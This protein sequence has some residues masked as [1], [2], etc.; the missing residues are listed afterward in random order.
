MQDMPLAVGRVPALFALLAHILLAEEQV[1]AQCVLLALPPAML[2]P[3]GVSAAQL[4][5]TDLVGDCARIV[6]QGNTVLLSELIALP[7][8]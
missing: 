6:Q 5:P 1:C 8:V 4:A 7:P 3:Q 2:E